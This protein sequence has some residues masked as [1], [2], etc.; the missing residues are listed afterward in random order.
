MITSCV[1]G[2]NPSSVSEPSSSSPSSDRS[3][4]LKR[5]GSN[6]GSSSRE[7]DC[8]C[9]APDAAWP[10]L[11]DAAC[12]TPVSDAGRA[13]LELAA[14]PRMIVPRRLDPPAWRPGPGTSPGWLEPWMERPP[15]LCSPP[16]AA[17]VALAEGFPSA[18]GAS[19]PPQLHSLPPPDL[20][21]ENTR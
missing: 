5:A 7:R 13:V 8:T 10:W 1:C 3:P 20:R 21:V 15:R 6:A 2:T 12:A 18:S 19:S 17:R 4:S 16:G 11:A 9:T 14:G